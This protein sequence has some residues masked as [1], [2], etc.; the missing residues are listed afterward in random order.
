MTVTKITA[1]GKSRDNVHSWGK[2]VQSECKKQGADLKGPIPLPQ[3]SI[4]CH[5]EDYYVNVINKENSDENWFSQ[6]QFSEEEKNNLYPESGKKNTIFGRLLVIDSDSV[7]KSVLDAEV[8][9]ELFLRVHVEE[10]HVPNNP[11]SYSHGYD[12]NKDYVTDID[13]DAHHR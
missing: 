8:D 1:F 4:S 6:L 3:I 12:P 2:S 7:V 5:N 13:F 10:S 11:G 9:R